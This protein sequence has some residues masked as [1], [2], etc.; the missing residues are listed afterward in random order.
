VTVL[1]QVPLD[2]ADGAATVLVEADRG[3]IPGGLALA[4]PEPG[5]AAA[6]AARSFSASLEQLEPI[7]R[8]VKEKLV[9]AAPE[10]FTVEFGV[11]LG[12]ETGIIVAKGTGEVNLKITMTWDRNREH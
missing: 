1:M 5:Q 11:K 2:D 7:L 10:H 4:S 3:D 12:G 8:T 6:K 9:S